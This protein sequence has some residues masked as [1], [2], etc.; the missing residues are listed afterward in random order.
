MTKAHIAMKPPAGT[1]LDRFV[2]GFLRPLIGRVAPGGEY[3]A[4]YTLA[5][6]YVNRS[7]VLTFA[8]NSRSFEVWLSPRDDKA[9]C[10]RR[11]AQYNIMYRGEIP[12]AGGRG[13]LDGLCTRVARHERAVPPP[14]PGRVLHY[15]PDGTAGPLDLVPAGTDLELRVTLRCNESCDFCNTDI[16]VDNV[17]RT[18]AD[19]TR[20]IDAAPAMG[21]RQIVF[22]GGEPTL[23]AQLPGWVRRAKGRCL[24]VCIQTNGVVP[25]DA[26]YWERYRGSDGALCLPEMLFVS[27]HT[28]K[29]RR[30]GRITGTPGTFA[31]KVQAIK[32]AL[33]LGIAVVINF[34]ITTKNLD[35]VAA[36]PAFVAN[37]FGPSVKINYSFVA[38]NGRVRENMHL[39]PRVAAA[40]PHLARA[41]DAADARGVASWITDVCGFPVCALTSHRGH[42]EGLKRAAARGA[43]SKDRVKRADCRRCIYDAQCTGMWARYV[44]RH[45]FGEFPPVTAP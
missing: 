6:I 43:L 34:V 31:R 40:A 18:P 37:R 5:G 20:A 24:T 45:G 3:L 10:Y 11:T 8:K 36:L 42:F 19:V 23:M 16:S 14:R 44:D 15:A 1:S 32:T 2:A 9:P 30:V 25:R 26:R 29:P 41:F 7:V 38:P 28:T 35:E 12:D 22:T 33:D 27:F 13:L 21:I 17:I 4:G 39:I